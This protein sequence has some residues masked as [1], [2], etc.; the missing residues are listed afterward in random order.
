MREIEEDRN[1]R[2]DVSCSWIEENIIQMATI[3]QITCKFKAIPLNVS[4]AFLLY[5][6]KLI[7]KVRWK[8]KWL[9]IDNLAK[10]QS[11][12]IHIFQSDT[13]NIR[14]NNQY[15]VVL[16]KDRHLDQAAKAK[17]GKLGSIKIV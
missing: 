12:R 5:I 6:D 2:K 7:L 16:A 13:N 9:S 8:W 17:I 10:Q 4:P 15:S 11:W 14:H 1:K 3:P